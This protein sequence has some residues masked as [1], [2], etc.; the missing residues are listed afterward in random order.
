M[1]AR[2]ER[3]SGIPSVHPMDAGGRRVPRRPFHS[4]FGGCGDHEPPRPPVAG[5]GVAL[6][7][8]LRVGALAAGGTLDGLPVRRR[9]GGWLSRSASPRAPRGQEFQPPWRPGGPLPG[10]PHAEGGP[11][12]GTAHGIRLLRRSCRPPL[13]GPEVRREGD[14]AIRCHGPPVLPGSGAGRGGG[15]AHPGLSGPGA[16]GRDPVRGSPA[17][18]LPPLDPPETSGGRSPCPTKETK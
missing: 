8:G 2:G 10:R 4:R 9:I 1:G 5:G 16:S 14:P 3:L 12:H 11:S 17:G 7:R 18:P 13:R 6:P 15:G